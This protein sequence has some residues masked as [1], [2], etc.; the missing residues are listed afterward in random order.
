LLE[1]LGNCGV[2]NTKIGIRI[3]NQKYYPVHWD[4]DIS[5]LY[6]KKVIDFDN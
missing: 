6:L 3:C 2:A 1:A 5:T 4:I